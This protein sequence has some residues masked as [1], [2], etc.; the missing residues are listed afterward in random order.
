VV[1]LLHEASVGSGMRRIEA[2][3]GPDAIR[4]VNLERRLLD[5]V[6]AA[7]GGGRPD[8]APERLRRIIAENKR[9]QN[10]IG[11]MT[12]TDRQRLVEQLASSSE[13]VGGIRYVL[14]PEDR[15]ADTLRQLAQSVVERLDTGQGSVAVLWTGKDGKALIV[16]AVSPNL[17]GRGI[18]A[19]RLL[20]T[21]GTMIGG[22]A[23]GKPTLA[24]AGGKHAGQV[25]AAAESTRDVLRDLLRRA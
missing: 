20:E 22:G 18:T 14:R 6:V 4:Q 24:F 9:L 25:K 7:L 17:A 5:E 15:D 11:K 16:A 13:V 12:A 21:A 2:L 19:P 8:D 3:V 10:E 23:G 1:R